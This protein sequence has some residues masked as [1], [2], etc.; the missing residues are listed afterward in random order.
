MGKQIWK[1][2]TFEY[3]NS[4]DLKRYKV[5]SMISYL[6]MGWCVIIK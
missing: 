5:F 2:V 6:A 1:A 4:I 3:P